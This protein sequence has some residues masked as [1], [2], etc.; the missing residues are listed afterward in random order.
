MRRIMKW[1]AWLL[2]WFVAV[3][4]A[5]VLFYRWVPVEVT[6]L[7]V[8]RWVHPAGEKQAFTGWKHQWV[9]LKEMSKWMP[10]AVVSGED[11]RFYDHHGF[12]MVE[13]KN[14]LKEADQGKRQRGASTITQQT[15]KN[16]FLWPGHSWVR[17]GLEAYF[18][19]LIELM[20]PKERILEVYLNSIEMA[21]GVYGAEA[22]AQ[23]HFGVSAK[24]LSKSQCALIAAALPDPI[25]RNPARPSKYLQ[26]R[27]R[28]IMR[29]M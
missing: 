5:G 27:K 19:V 28:Q 26:K 4:A 29:Y 6:P 13:I 21:P 18:T 20:W 22:M 7:M 2:F 14:A 25:G 10:K 12:D 23:T 8:M 1:A 11:Q 17:K 3:S 16:V 9:P 24:D 15:A